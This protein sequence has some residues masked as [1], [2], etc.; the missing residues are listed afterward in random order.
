MANTPENA[1][2]NTPISSLAF[3]PTAVLHPHP[4]HPLSH[5]Q[6]QPRYGNN[7]YDKQFKKQIT[8]SKIGASS[9]FM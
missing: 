2:R 5:Y 4:N 6:T 3:H 1:S 8:K 9:C 7:E